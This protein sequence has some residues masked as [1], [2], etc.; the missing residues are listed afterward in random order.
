MHNN[1]SILTVI[2]GIY[3]C[4][5]TLPDALDSLLNQTFN[6][7]KIILCDDGSTDSTYEVASSYSKRYSNIILLRNE[8]NQGLNYTLNHCLK[9]ADT[10][11]VA[12]MDGD[13]ISL[14]TRFEKQLSY[15]TNHPEIDFVSSAMIYFDEKGDYKTG[16]VVES[17]TKYDFVHGTPFCH[18]PCM[19]RREAYEAVS[20]YSEERRLLRVEDYHLWFKM[21][22]KGFRGVNLKEPLYKMRDDRNAYSRRKFKYRINEMYV[23]HI[24]YKMLKLPFYYQIYTLRPILV[25]LM[26]GWLYQILHKRNIKK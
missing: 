10:E 24:G 16:T 20:G 4:S 23:R 13:D 12:R 18:A 15:L 11:F 3:N 9:Y 21:Y 25:G 17:P 8:K 26:P 14:P 19:V 5:D 1:Q 6:L 22:A 7:F 2:I